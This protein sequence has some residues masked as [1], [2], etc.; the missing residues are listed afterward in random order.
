MVTCKDNHIEITF[1]SNNEICPLCIVIE[2][3][4]DMFVAFN[5][6]MVH[7]QIP[8]GTENSYIADRVLL[9]LKATK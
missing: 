7:D 9:A 6:A 4:M 2:A 1:K 3:T 5:L 8:S